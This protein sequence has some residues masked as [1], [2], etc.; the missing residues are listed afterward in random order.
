MWAFLY[1]FSSNFLLSSQ[2]KV[3]WFVNSCRRICIME[4]SV[5]NFA[6]GLII[7][8][9]SL[10]NFIFRSVLQRILTMRKFCDDIINKLWRFENKPLTSC[11][12]IDAAHFDKG[13]LVF[14]TVEVSSILQCVS[15]LQY[16]IGESRD[17]WVRTA[18]CSC[19][20]FEVK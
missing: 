15:V 13:R 16:S 11:H 7:D 5:D 4:E 18:M 19:G 9:L 14:H 6:N 8:S 12:C 20:M 10:C 1:C 2:N 17:W 3:V